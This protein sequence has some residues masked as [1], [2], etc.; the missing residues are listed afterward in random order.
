M[1]EC[2]EELCPN[3]LGDGRVCPCAL[4]DIEPW[5][6]NCDLVYTHDGRLCDA[7]YTNPAKGPAPS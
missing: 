7:C 1:A 3:W 2:R 4:F 6:P 5:C